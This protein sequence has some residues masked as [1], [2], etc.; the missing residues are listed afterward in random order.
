MPAVAV[1]C[2]RT[3]AT[4]VRRQVG[5]VQERVPV[6]A[7]RWKRAFVLDHRSAM[8]CRYSLIVGF[9]VLSVLLA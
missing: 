3:R 5:V 6:V 9:S 7:R 8:S 2:G 1:R 4:Q